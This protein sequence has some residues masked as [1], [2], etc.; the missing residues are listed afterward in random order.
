M[1]KGSSRRPKGLVTDKNLE[2]N[3]ERIFGAKPNATQFE[4]N[5]AIQQHKAKVAWRD[6]MVQEDH[7]NYIKEKNG[8]DESNTTV[9][10][11]TKK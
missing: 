5:G 9:T 8:Q 7:N 6:E 2:D 11:K 1:S 4:Q 10:K 3:W